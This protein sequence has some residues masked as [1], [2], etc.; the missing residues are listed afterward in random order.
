MAPVQL[1]SVHAFALFNFL[2]SRIDW[3]WWSLRFAQFTAK[4][5]LIFVPHVWLSSGYVYDACT[6][7]LHDPTLTQPPAYPLPF[8]SPWLTYTIYPLAHC[9]TACLGL[10]FIEFLLVPP[11]IVWCRSLRNRA[12]YGILY[13]H[14]L[15]EMSRSGK[16]VACSLM[17]SAY[18]LQSCL[19]VLK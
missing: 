18:R 14:V 12:W 3:G 19:L 17:L 1:P 7:P 2:P 15:G 11:L 5:T 10:S 4:V 16:A 9:H 6:P 13:I 8:Y